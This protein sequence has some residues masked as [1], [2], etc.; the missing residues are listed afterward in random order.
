MRMD[1]CSLKEIA[2]AAGFKTPSAVSKHIEK[3]A[4]A[5]E[6]YVSGEYGSFLGLT[7]LTRTTGGK[8]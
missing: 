4:G 5:Y 7:L 2:A 3:I 8:T 6:D 1:G